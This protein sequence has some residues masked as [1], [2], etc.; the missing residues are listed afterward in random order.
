ML[1]KE[2]ES[3]KRL[4]VEAG[5]E[6]LKFYKGNF[7]VEEKNEDGRISPLTSADIAANNLIIDG[8]K[9]FTYPI[10]SE[11]SK[12]D[13]SRFN[14]EYVWIVD[15]LDGTKNFL[16]RKG[17]FTVNISLVKDHEPII[18][19]IYVPLTKTLFF[20]AA[21]KGAFIAFEGKT[22]RI[23]VS[24]KENLSE[25]I[26]VNSINH[27]QPA[28]DH[29]APLFKK[30]FSVGSS[31]KGCLVAEGKADV[32]IRFGPTSEWDICAMKIIITESGGR[33]TF[34]DGKEIRFNR[35]DIRNYGFIACNKKV[36][37]KILLAVK[38]YL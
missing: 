33:M 24:D 20:A 19:V 37:G 15:P 21:G 29:I 35:K 16:E 23:K 4:A 38:P 36:H 17:E 26:L 9:K 12:D 3:A 14:S 25:M 22:T 5:L 34:I 7:E 10:L 6:I 27:K 28:L 8:L 31:L 2:L 30:Q 18:G 13:L 32:Y 11:E 1:K